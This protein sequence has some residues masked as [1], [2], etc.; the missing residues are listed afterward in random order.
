MFIKIP[1]EQ[2]KDTPGA[3][4]F[5]FFFFF[6][7]MNKLTERRLECLRQPAGTLASDRPGE[8]QESQGQPLTSFLVAERCE[9]G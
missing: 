8:K 9:A 2:A 4:V 7:H 5:H 3:F 6:L 1:T